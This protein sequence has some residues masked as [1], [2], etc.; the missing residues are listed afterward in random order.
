MYLLSYCIKQYANHGNTNDAR[1]L[2]VQFCTFACVQFRG[3]ALHLVANLKYYLTMS[4]CK[5]IKAEMENQMFRVGADCNS[6]RFNGSVILDRNL[7][8]F[9]I[10]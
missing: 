8:K 2:D 3:Y 4:N 1:F 9:M 6:F 10:V 7:L 5:R